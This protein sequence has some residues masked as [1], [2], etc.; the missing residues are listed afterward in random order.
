MGAQKLKKEKAEK[1]AERALKEATSKERVSKEQ[2]AK[3]AERRTKE[4]E[5]ATKERE[6]KRK[7]AD[8][9]E[10]AQKAAVAAE[11]KVKEI[12]SKKCGTRAW[13]TNYWYAWTDC[14]QGC[15]GRAPSPGGL[16]GSC[17]WKR[18]YNWGKDKSQCGCQVTPRG[19]TDFKTNTYYFNTVDMYC[20]PQGIC[21]DVSV[22]MS[23]A[24]LSTQLD[25]L[26]NPLKKSG[27]SA[28][29]TGRNMM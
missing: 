18:K 8:A 11:Q 19:T 6:N 22:Y 17:I 27:S 5:K 21:M 23:D 16:A 9:K 24:L 1:K 14:C 4:A 20:S 25:L 29:D 13:S 12:K 3:A 2:A 7:E 26:F 28:S 15:D 10:K